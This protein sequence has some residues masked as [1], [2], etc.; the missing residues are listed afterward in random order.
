MDDSYCPWRSVNPTLGLSGLG[1]VRGS[2][3]TVSEVPLERV[4]NI[5]DIVDLSEKERRICNS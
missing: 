5:R 1:T 4:M 3:W 2:S